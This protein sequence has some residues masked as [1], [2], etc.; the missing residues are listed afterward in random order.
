MVYDQLQ[1]RRWLAGP[2]LKPLMVDSGIELHQIG[3]LSPCLK[4]AIAES[5]LIGAA[6]A[7]VLLEIFS[8][9]QCLIIFSC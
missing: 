6:C 8:R 7:G 5:L 9:A 3:V 1:G 2:L 4:Q